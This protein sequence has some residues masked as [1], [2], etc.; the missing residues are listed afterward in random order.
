MK[1]ENLELG[2]DLFYKVR[3]LEEVDLKIKQI[4]GI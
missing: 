4:I 3:D 1:I 2:N